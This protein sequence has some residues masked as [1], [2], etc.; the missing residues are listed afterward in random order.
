VRYQSS[1]IQV[2]DDMAEP[3]GFDVIDAS[4][5]VDRVFESLKKAISKVVEMD[6]PAKSRAKRKM[7]VPAKKVAAR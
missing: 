1:L 4:Q 6:V 5:P 2:F 3:Y 7:A